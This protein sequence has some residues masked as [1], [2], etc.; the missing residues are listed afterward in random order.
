MFIVKETDAFPGPKSCTYPGVGEAGRVSF[1]SQNLAVGS[2]SVYTCED[3]YE[4]EG[5]AERSCE[6]D[7]RWSGTI[8]LCKKKKCANVDIWSGGGIVRLLNGTNEYGNE[9]CKTYFAFL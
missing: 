7:A 6:D 8:P 1:S 2:F 3:G 9:V 5:E 4:L